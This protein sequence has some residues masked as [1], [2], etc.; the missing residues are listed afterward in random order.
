[1]LTTP[2]FTPRNSRCKCDLYLNVTS[3]SEACAISS[4]ST[5]LEKGRTPPVGFLRDYGAVVVDALSNKRARSVISCE[6]L[7]LNT[8]LRAD[9]DAGVPH[10]HLPLHAPVVR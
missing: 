4:A 7:Y 9:A 2:L 5:W 10:P 6:S 1:M 3:L 8:S